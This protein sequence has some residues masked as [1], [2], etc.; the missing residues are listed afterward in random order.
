V[1]QRLGLAGA[2]LGDPQVLIADEP[3]NGLDPEGIAWLRRLLRDAAA[4]G[5]TVLVSSHFLAEVTRTADRLLVIDKGELR[6]DG[7]LA[8]L[9]GSGADAA[10][11]EDAFLKLTSGVPA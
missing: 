1:R 5:R 11:L 3:A 2:L 8:E 6:F 4:E 9:A 7:D 10:A